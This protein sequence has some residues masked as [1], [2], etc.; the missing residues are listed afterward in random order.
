MTW[1]DRKWPGSDVIWPEV[2]W[3]WLL[4]AENWRIPH[5]SLPRRLQLAGG[6]SHVTGNDIMWP[7]VTGSAQEVTSF[8]GSHLEVAVEGRILACIVHFTS[9]K[10]AAHRGGS[11]VTG[12]D[13]TWPQVTG[14]ALEVTSFDRK[15]PGTGCRRPKTAVY[16]TFHLL[17][18]CSSQKEPVSR[19]KWRHVTS[20]DRKW[21]GSD[22]I[23]PVVTLKWLWKAENW[24]IL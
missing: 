6:G 21:P 13:V 4:K 1:R 20:G 9:Y 22:V 24:R 11:H 2:T 15:S 7:Q 10:A 3:N 18:V 23:W 16:C 17:Q 14:S 5:I 8:T 12:N 19:S